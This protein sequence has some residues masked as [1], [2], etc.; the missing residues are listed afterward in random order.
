MLTESESSCDWFQLKIPDR[1]QITQGGTNTSHRPRAR[2][3]FLA[4]AIAKLSGDTVYKSSRTKDHSI[5]EIPDPQSQHLPRIQMPA[6]QRLYHA[7]VP[8][9]LNVSSNQG[10]KGVGPSKEESQ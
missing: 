7:S 8:E 2:L 10:V 4:E 9:M 3:S 5:R 6:G 1:C